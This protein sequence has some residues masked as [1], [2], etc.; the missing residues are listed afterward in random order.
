MAKQIRLKDIARKLGL[1]PATV[2]Q[3]FNNPKLINRK[4]RQRVF[5]L[6]NESGYVRKKYKKGRNNAIGILGESF[7]I[8]LGGFY[9][10]VTTS[11]LQY[12]HRK[13]IN[14]LIGSFEADDDLL[15]S[16]VTKGLVDG[17]VLIGRFTRENVMR[18]KQENLPLVLCGNPIPGVELHTVVPDGRAG[19][20]AVTRHLL[21][22]GHK[23]ITTITGGPL[24]DPIT[25]DRLDGYRFAL[26]EAGLAFNE[27]SIA[28]ANFYDLSTVAAAVGKLLAQLERPTAI[29]C[30]C[31]AI[32]YTAIQLLQEKGI[33]V[34]QDISV[35]GFDDLP[36]P[37]F[38]E[39][40]KPQL[41]S[42]RVDL[43]QLGRVAVDVLAEIIANPAKSAYRHTLPTELIVRK[44]SVPPFK[45]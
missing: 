33:R 38:I 28:Q 26:A 15:P 36:F 42:A 12:A 35:T 25:S 16:M 7:Y 22:L 3:A 37:D 32:A 39:P 8:T 10:F 5:E 23:K 45:A 19:I 6:C 34:P 2:S 18:L 24:F 13:K 14:T 43:E 11:L 29:V 1:S 4:T 17:L 31:D 30:A 27:R 40:Y 9:N 41:T 21:D 20:Y 44:T